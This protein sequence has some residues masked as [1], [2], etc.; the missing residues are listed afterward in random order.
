M[1]LEV[2]SLYISNIHRNMMTVAVTLDKLMCFARES[3]HSI[4]LR[5]PC[6]I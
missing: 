1:K 5:W 2:I 6:L 4:V 3:L